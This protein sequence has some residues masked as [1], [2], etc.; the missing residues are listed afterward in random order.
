[1]KPLSNYE[2]LTTIQNNLNTLNKRYTTALS[3][4]LHKYELLLER[5]T[6]HNELLQGK[7]LEL[8]SS[9]SKIALV[10]DKLLDLKDKVESQ[11]SKIFFPLPHQVTLTFKNLKKDLNGLMAETKYLQSKIRHLAST[12]LSFYS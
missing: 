5:I 8:N 6:Y 10:E 12:Q 9:M 4:S 7:G 11:E 2:S 3:T 1:Q